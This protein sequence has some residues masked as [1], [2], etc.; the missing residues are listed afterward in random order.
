MCKRAIVIEI[1]AT[2]LACNLIL[3]WVKWLPEPA[4]LNKKHKKKITHLKNHF[5]III[6]YVGLSSP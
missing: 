6:T 1:P 3:M 5:E 4:L 2:F